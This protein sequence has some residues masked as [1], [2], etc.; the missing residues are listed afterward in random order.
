M[1]KSL[2]CHGNN[3][4]LVIEK[5]MLEVL[6]I[7]EETLLEITTD[8]YSIIITPVKDKSRKKLVR[9]AVEKAKKKHHEALKKLAE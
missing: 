8:G 1:R 4:A 6:G 9:E 2:I 3:L 7:N 5:P